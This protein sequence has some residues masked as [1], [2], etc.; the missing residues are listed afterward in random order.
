MATFRS[1]EGD[2][3]VVSTYIKK[4]YF[5][6]VTPNSY[7]QCELLRSTWISLVQVGRFK[8]VSGFYPELYVVK[9]VLDK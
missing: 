1:W 5:L 4:H 2:T 3:V 9:S 8:G 7:S 6:Q